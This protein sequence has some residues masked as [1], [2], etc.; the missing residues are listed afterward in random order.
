MEPYNFATLCLEPHRATRRHTHKCKVTNMRTGHNNQC[1]CR[2]VCRSIYVFI[3]LQTADC[4]NCRL[5]TLK[6]LCLVRVTCVS[7]I[8]ICAFARNHRADSPS[9]EQNKVSF[10]YG[11]CCF[12]KSHYPQMSLYSGARTRQPSLVFLSREYSVQLGLPLQELQ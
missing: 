10:I 6:S 11:Y 3:F 8:I 7:F 2:R 5:S 9:L 4:H 12:P 1:H